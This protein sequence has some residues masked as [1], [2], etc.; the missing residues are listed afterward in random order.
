M[1]TG[2]DAPGRVLGLCRVVVWTTPLRSYG[3]IT[4][5]DI[6]FVI[7]GMAN[8][9]VVKGNRELFHITDD[10]VQRSNTLVQVQEII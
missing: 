8:V 7:P 2:S 1:T 4:G 9:T 3:R 6:N 5:Y 10:R